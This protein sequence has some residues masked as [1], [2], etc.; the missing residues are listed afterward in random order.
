M[1]TSQEVIV[2]L[3]YNRKYTTISLYIITVFFLCLV[4]Y[5]L[6][7]TWEDSIQLVRD[8]LRLMAPFV[9][10][11]FV[12]YFISPMVNFF[13]NK[14]LAKIHIGNRYIRSSKLLRVVSIITSYLIVVGTV[15]FLLA[16]ILPQLAESFYEITKKLPGYI[17][18]VISWSET[19]LFTIGDN[20]YIVDMDLLNS[21]V[22]DSLPQSL[23][24]ITD[25][26]NKFAP[27]ILNATKNIASGILNIVFGFI[28]AIYLIFNKE[29]YMSNTRKLI[30]AILP[31][32][33]TTS[34]FKTLSD[35][36]KIFSK[37][38]IGKLIDSLIIGLMC[39]VIM[40]VSRIPYAMLISVIVGV[41]N[42]IPYFGP[43]IGGAVGIVFLL[44]SAPVKAFWFC[45]IIIG[46]QQFDGNI[47]G[48]KI[49]GDSTG[50]TPFWVI[51]S[52]I[53]FGGMFGILGMFIGVP[54]FA[55]I[56]NIFDNSID[57]MYR[58]KMALQTQ[59]PDET[60]DL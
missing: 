58:K 13:E 60:L 34:F 7:F 10:S 53:L 28:I 42:M 23:G 24:Q 38:F 1:N 36:H 45:I 46:L 18:S 35:S 51:F 14:I 22:E 16:I 8:F 26:F 17:D 4:V 19:A 59:A 27:D 54:C 11:L 40:L 57:R 33:R 31:L 3:N 52:I 15:V 48:P 30:T 39:F 29:S 50:L 5:R 9:I 56:K 20:S 43:F 47:L 49:L 37:F 44:I 32:H 6:T 25:I 2:K 41:T 21:F 55:V 12:A